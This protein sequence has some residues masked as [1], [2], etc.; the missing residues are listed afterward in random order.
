MIR[1]RSSYLNICDPSEFQAG[2]VWPLPQKIHYGSE[3]RTVRQGSLA[4]V[5]QG[6]QPEY[7]DILEHAKNTY[8][9]KK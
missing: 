6:Q 9:K 4:M 8:S 1:F 3:N 7:C 5:F 2:T